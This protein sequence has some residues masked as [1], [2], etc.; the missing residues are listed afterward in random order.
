MT[1]FI[2][3][4]GP[5]GPITVVAGADMEHAATIK[6]TAQKC[7]SLR[8]VRYQIRYT[9]VA[10][11][12]GKIG[13]EVCESGLEADFKPWPLLAAA[14]TIVD[15]DGVLTAG[16]VVIG[17]V[18]AGYVLL[19]LTDVFGFVRPYYTSTG[20]GAGDTLDIVQGAR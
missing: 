4:E 19:N 15:G 7:L 11:P 2:D 3:T 9:D 18:G 16:A 14:V 17:G 8:N 20:G 5:N 6:G 12:A 10:S 13:V 1:T